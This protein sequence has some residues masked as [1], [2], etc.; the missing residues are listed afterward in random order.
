[1][2]ECFRALADLV[3]HVENSFDQTKLLFSPVFFHFLKIASRTSGKGITSCFSRNKKF[4]Q[5]KI[6]C[7]P[8][9]SAQAMRFQ[10]ST[11]SGSRSG[12]LQ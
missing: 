10:R 4:D 8:D 11:C 12:K 3:K 6:P 5:L 2:S 1:M 7:S 9:E